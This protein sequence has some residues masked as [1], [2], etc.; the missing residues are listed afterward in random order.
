MERLPEIKDREPSPEPYFPTP[1]E[2][3]KARDVI[4]R[5]WDDVVGVKIECPP[6]PPQLSPKPPISLNQSSPAQLSD[7][8]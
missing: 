2:Q 4:T 3:K 7:V 8:P 1:E 5:G 6:A